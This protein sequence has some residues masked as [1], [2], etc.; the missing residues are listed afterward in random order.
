[1]SYIDESGAQDYFATRV[2]ADAWDYSDS[3]QRE[4]A[5]AHATRI[6]D[7]LNL[8]GQKSTADQDNEFPRLGQSDVPIDITNACCEI[9]LSLLDGVNIEL[10]LENLSL[11]NQAYANV[12]STYDRSSLPEH[13][14]A[15]VPS[16]T[17]WRFLKPYV[18]D[19]RNFNMIRVS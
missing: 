7:N 4:K 19:G 18:I 15:G 8:K 9:A 12:K 10:E 2:G 5:L 11:V 1:M 14:L 16:S 6:I 3:A 13:I 17:A